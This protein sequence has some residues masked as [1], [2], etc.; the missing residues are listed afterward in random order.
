MH[1]GVLGYGYICARKR[2]EKAY[3]SKEITTKA[4]D[5]RRDKMCVKRC[6]TCVV[7]DNMVMTD[8]WEAKIKDRGR[9]FLRHHL[10]GRGS[11]TGNGGRES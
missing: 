9:A 1:V 3:D 7:G 11:T 2:R 5:W 4:A 10:A 8:G 6:Y